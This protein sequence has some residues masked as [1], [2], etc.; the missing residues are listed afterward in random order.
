M[1]SSF[2]GLFESRIEFASHP[3][4]SQPLVLLVDLMTSADYSLLLSVLPCFIQPVD[5]G[6]LSAVKVV[7]LLAVESNVLEVEF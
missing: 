2:L 7:G 5:A 6:A 4:V 3:S 1:F